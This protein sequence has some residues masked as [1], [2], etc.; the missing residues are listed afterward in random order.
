M[1]PPEQERADEPTM[2]ELEALLAAGP[3]RLREAVEAVLSGFRP[4]TAATPR[5]R[6]TLLYYPS[7]SAVP[8]HQPSDYDFVQL[9]EDNWEAIYAEYLQVKDEPAG[10]EEIHSSVSGGKWTAFNLWAQG[11]KQE[12]NCSLAPVTTRLLES[13]P[14]FMS[15]SVLKPGTHINTHCGPANVKLRCHLGLET[16]PN[17]T[18]RVAEETRG[19]EQGKC[20]VF[21]DSFDH[22]VAHRGDRDRVVLL[23]DVWHPDLT[24]VERTAIRRF[25]K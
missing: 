10:Y 25:L 20:I 21:D 19:W 9:L 16:P 7:L 24:Q 18:I 1:E 12:H 14:S 15:G 4:L 17:C 23:I 22:E 13:I 6:P 5:Q 2:E 8:W 11:V 3:P